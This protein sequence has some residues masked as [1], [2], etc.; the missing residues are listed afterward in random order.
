MSKC[1]AVCGLFLW[2]RRNWCS[3]SSDRAVR[4]WTWAICVLK[5]PALSLLCPENMSEV[6]FKGV[7]KLFGG[8][9]FKIG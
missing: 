2:R 9:T 1:I 8:G 6:G 4:N 5:D 3:K 7:D